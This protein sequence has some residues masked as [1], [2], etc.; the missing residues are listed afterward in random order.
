[1]ESNLGLGLSGVATTSLF[2][3]GVLAKLAELGLLRRIEVIC[4]LRPPRR[5]EMVV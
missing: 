4:V 2:H 5:G 3:I 1:M